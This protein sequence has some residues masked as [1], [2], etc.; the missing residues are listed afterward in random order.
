MKLSFY[1]LIGLFV[2]FLTLL[3]TRLIFQYIFGEILEEHILVLRELINLGFVVFVLWILKNKENQELSSIGLKFNDWKEILKMT[4]ISFVFTLG[5]MFITLF[6]IQYF[7]LPFGES[8]AFEKL[9]FVG[10]TVICIRAGVAEEIFFRGYIYEKFNTL[11]QNKWVAIALS[12][13]PFALLH[14]TQGVAG[15]IISFV[16]GFAFHLTYLWKKNL[17]ANIIAH[18]LI[19]FLANIG[20]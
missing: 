12:V 17:T 6:I 14:Y 13:I 5:I 10:I 3:V 11:F 2:S 1:T 18:F 8:K 19:D 4:V 16:A 7:K 15:I 9:S 20:Q